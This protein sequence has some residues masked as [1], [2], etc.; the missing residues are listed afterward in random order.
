MA[1][2]W[3]NDPRTTIVFLLGAAG[4][5]KTTL[6]V[7]A[8]VQGLETGAYDNI[9][10]TRVNVEAGDRVGFLPGGTDSKNEPWVATM[11]NEFHK[12]VGEGNT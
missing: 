7:A 3:L 5:G 4:G 10:L 9:L 12:W 8:G 11:L 6:A 1:L 2:H